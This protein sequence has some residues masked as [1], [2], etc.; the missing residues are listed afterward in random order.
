MVYP[1][2]QKQIASENGGRGVT[3]FDILDSN[4]KGIFDY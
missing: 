4:F 2:N 3:T 1:N